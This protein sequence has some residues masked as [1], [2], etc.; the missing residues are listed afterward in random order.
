MVDTAFFD[1]EGLSPGAR[2]DGPAIIAEPTTTLVVPPG[3][4]ALLS[5]GDTYVLHTGVI[6]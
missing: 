6:R 3:A 1:G 5:P 4:S 2:I